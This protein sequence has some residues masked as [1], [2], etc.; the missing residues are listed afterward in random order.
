VKLTADER[1]T[2][3]TAE[4]HRWWRF[5][6]PAAC[7]LGKRYACRGED[8]TII[9]IR[10]LSKAELWRTH[11]K[12]VNRKLLAEWPDGVESVW[13]IIARR[14]DWTD[15]PRY[16]TRRSR[17]GGQSADYTMLRQKAVHEEPEALSAVELAQLTRARRS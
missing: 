2:F 9:D 12:M 1:K 4:V 7:E 5:A 17:D 14:G 8:Y 11:S 16:L 6:L 10:Q 13:R 3:M 15:K